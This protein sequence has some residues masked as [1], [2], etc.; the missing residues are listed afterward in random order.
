[1]ARPRGLVVGLDGLELTGD[2]QHL[3]ADCDPLGVIF[4][5]R[6]V[7]DPSQVRNLAATVRDCLGRD[8]APVLI[9]QEGG[10]V[11]RLRPPLWRGYPS[12]RRIGEVAERAPDAGE[13]LAR[14]VAL[15]IAADLESLGIDW[16]CAPVL[17]LL[18]PETHGVIGDRAYGGDPELVA[19]LGQAAVQ[20][21]LDGGVVP[22]VKHLPG[23]GRATA[24]SHHLLPT[25]LASRA[26]LAATDFVPFRRLADAPAAMTAHIRY[27]AFDLPQSFSTSSRLIDEVARGTLGFGGLLF[28]DD[29]D[30]QA[31][32]GSVGRRVAAVLDAGHDVA[33]QCNGR[34]EDQRAA[35]EAATEMTAGAWMRYT[36][37]RERLRRSRAGDVDVA[38]LDAELHAAGV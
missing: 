30:M 6:N 18:R 20:G 11:A 37:A 33:L 17:D 16:V 15:R 14:A 29:V 32:E 28:S 36:S 25:V 12:Q 22:I 27:T 38:A 9:D 10:R 23:H 1:M 34:P 7:S 13:R 5:A 3:L 8:D 24:D 19:R 35:L 2:E 21:F 26:E 31:L 4:F